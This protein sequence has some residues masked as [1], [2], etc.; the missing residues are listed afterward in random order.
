MSYY[1]PPIETRE[2]DELIVICKSKTLEWHENVISLVKNEL[3]KRGLKDTKIKSRY[4]ELGKKYKEQKEIELKDTLQEDYSL[5]EKILILLFWPRELFYGW[6]LRRDGNSL[7][8]K[9]RM[10]LIGL[11]IILYFILIITSF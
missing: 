10:Q 9:H 2:T 11:G 7:K 8:A 3:E 4:L 5:F 1:L 6:Y